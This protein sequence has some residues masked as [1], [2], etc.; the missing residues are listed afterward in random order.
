MRGFLTL[1]R[2]PTDYSGAHWHFKGRV[3]GKS[4]QLTDEDILEIVEEWRALIPE[5]ALVLLEELD[6]A[7]NRFGDRGGV[8]LFDFLRERNVGVKVGR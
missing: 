2:D 4:R 8:A 3:M 1:R 7:M 5:S 6:L